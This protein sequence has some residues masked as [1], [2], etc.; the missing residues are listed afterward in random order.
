MYELSKLDKVMLF[1]LELFW[2]AVLFID[3]VAPLCSI[4]ALY[5]NMFPLQQ[6]LDDLLCACV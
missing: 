2:A 5:V 3:R 1:F 6:M 4:V